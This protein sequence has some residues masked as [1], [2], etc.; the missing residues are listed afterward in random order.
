MAK[1]AAGLLLGLAIGA[2]CRWLDI[3]VPSPPRIPG[4]LLVLAM[5]IGY[6]GTDWL[7]AARFTAKKAATTQNLCGGPTGSSAAGGE[8]STS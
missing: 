4:A 1:I 2:V 7:I 3:P 5:T 8:R 6:V